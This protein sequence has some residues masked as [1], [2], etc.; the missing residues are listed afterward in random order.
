MSDPATGLPPALPHWL[1]GAAAP[2]EAPPVAGRRMGGQR[3]AEK[4]VEAAR[5]FLVD[6]LGGGPAGGELGGGWLARVDARW[7]LVGLFALVLLVGLVHQV[8]A[9]LA[10][11][12][13][14]AVLAASSGLAVGR[15]LRRVWL[16][17]PLLT[18]VTVLPAATSW[19]TPGEPLLRLWGAAGAAPLRL[20]PVALPGALALTRPGV[21]G[22]LL[23]LLRVGDSL[24][25]ALLLS[26]TTRWS[27]LGRGLRALR[28]PGLLV[29]LLTM[30][31]RYLVVLAGLV[32]EL[33]LARRARPVAP[34]PAGVAGA[35]RS[36]RAGQRFVAAAATVLLLRSQ[37]VA[38]EV[39]LAMKARGYGLRKG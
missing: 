13:L 39:Y 24:A 22:A 29:T 11:Q 10:L 4:T 30:S 19:V 32:E 3:F 8:P 27:E 23:L 31:Q 15:F 9:L 35:T 14:A 2:E 33:F 34:P 1:R 20:G 7:K 5:A 37:Q 18:A 36:A 38:E 21:E 17:L 12:L 28:V 26:W 16:G 6:M 25:F